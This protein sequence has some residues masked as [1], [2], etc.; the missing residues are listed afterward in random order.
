MRLVLEGPA[1]APVSP[2][3]VDDPTR[4]EPPVPGQVTVGVQFAGLN[5]IDRLLAD[6]LVPRLA[7]QHVLGGQGAGRVTAVGE[8]VDGVA[9]GDTVALYPY[10]GCGECAACASGNETLC[11]N[12]RLD[13]V[14]SPGCCQSHFAAEARDAFAVPSPLTAKAAVL[15]PAL[16][17]AWHVLVCRGQLQAGE[18]VAIS[19]ISSGL[20]VCCGALA[21]HLGATVVG[22]ARQATL[23]RVDGFPSWL[24]QTVATDGDGRPRRVDLA[25][26]AVGAPTLPFVHRTLRTGGR[27]V[28]VG[29]H[30][31][32]EVT[33][34]LWRLFTREQDI[35]GSHG[36]HRADMT[37]ALE[38]LTSLDARSMIDSIFDIADYAAAYTRLDTAG[39]FG[40]VLLRF[41]S[42]EV[43]RAVRR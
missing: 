16:A 21:D 32:R 33:I 19:S 22:L 11:R 41:G 38:A 29:A 43:E 36:C 15:A 39:R 31:G 10:G 26:D 28:T 2:N 9:V 13:G 20:G 17:V 4:I 24:E 7:G 18:T 27:L 6:G 35:R 12:A 40:N 34:D 23:E 14:N 8:G 37:S 3:L 42:D 25:V 30:A 1:G 5:R